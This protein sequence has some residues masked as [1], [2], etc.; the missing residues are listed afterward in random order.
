MGVMGVMG[1]GG[2]NLSAQ[3]DLFPVRG[4]DHPP[5]PAQGEGLLMILKCIYPVQIIVNYELS[6]VCAGS[7]N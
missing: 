4:R 7:S 1:A 2:D 5:A 3:P 6:Q